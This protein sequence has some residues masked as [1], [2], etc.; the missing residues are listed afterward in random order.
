MKKI[1]FIILLFSV[2]VGLT[3]SANMDFSFSANGSS[4][5]GKMNRVGDNIYMHYNMNG[6]NTPGILNKVPNEQKEAVANVQGAE[7]DMVMNC[8]NEKFKINSFRITDATGFKMEST[9][10]AAWMPLTKE[11]DV[12]KLRELCGKL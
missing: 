12:Q 3:C 11:E 7:I 4:M 8:T 5:S 9:L 1:L 6:L 2:S 10:D